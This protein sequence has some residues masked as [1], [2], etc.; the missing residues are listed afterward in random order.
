MGN[1]RGPRRVDR[2]QRFDRVAWIQG[3]QGLQASQGV[4]IATP[5][6]EAVGRGGM[7]LRQQLHAAAECEFQKTSGSLSG[8]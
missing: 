3:F 5:A 7:W 2:L 6:S 1:S 8:S 4:K